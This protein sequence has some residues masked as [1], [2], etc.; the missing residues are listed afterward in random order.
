MD[1]D[2]H[3]DPSDN[4]ARGLFAIASALRALGTGNAA[5]QMGAIEALAVAVTEAS[6]RVAAAIADRPGLGENDSLALESAVE[7]AGTEIAAEIA[8]AI[9]NPEEWRARQ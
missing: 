6:E 9:A 7:L 5:T 8:L 2:A 4:I 1:Y 3:G